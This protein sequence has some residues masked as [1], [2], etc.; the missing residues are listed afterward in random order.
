[1]APELDV[2]T[3]AFS[4]TGRHIT[5][6]LLERGREVRTLTGHPDRP[7]PFG[8]RVAA[9]P[10]DFTR[11]DDLAR[12]LEGAD[13][14]YNT[15]WV[16]VARGA[17]THERAVAHTEVLLRAAARA[18]VR[19]V[20][21]ISITGVERGRGLPY[22]EGKARAE[23]LV[24]S[25]AP[26]WAI[27]RPTLI[28]GRQ[29]V[30]LHNIAWALRRF[31]VFPLFGDGN[32]PVQPV[33]VD[34]VADLAVRVGLGEERGAATGADGSGSGPGL[35][36]EAAGPDRLAYREMV[37]MVARA[38]GRRPLLVPAPPGAA[39]LGAAL[40]GTAMGDVAVTRDEVEGLMRGLLVAEGAAT[41]SR[42]LGDWLARHARDLGRHWR[43]EIERHYRRG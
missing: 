43:S 7:D 31:P 2:V 38:V 36:V 25:L 22:F 3:G 42:R 28:F 17:T 13:I 11:P 1:M 19:R 18:G 34:D 40:V 33:H 4:Y 35:V 41:G 9:R 15:Y 10:L 23:E 8:G 37:A 24:K 12:D 5:A 29:D 39:W 14:L 16:R 6:R 30:L 21:H 27:V 32:Y 26:S 20:V